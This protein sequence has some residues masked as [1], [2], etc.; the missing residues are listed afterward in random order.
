MDDGSEAVDSA[1]RAG[2]HPVEAHSQP[3]DYIHGICD[4]SV[5]SGCVWQSNDNYLQ[6][7]KV[8]IGVVKNVLSESVGFV[9]KRVVY[10]QA[11]STPVQ[12]VSHLSSPQ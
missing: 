11:N 5:N 3:E 7:S 2:L 1:T 9:L 10:L 12:N 4:G 6:C 8:P